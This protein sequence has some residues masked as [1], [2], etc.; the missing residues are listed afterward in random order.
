MKILPFQLPNSQLILLS[1]VSV[2]NR[3]AFTILLTQVKQWFNQSQNHLNLLVENEG[4]W[5]TIQNL[6]DLIPRKDEPD[7]YGFDLEDFRQ[8][9]EKLLTLVLVELDQLLE[10]SVEEKEQRENG[11]IEFT[12]PSSGDLEADLIADLC[13]S[14]GDVGL[15]I[16]E[17]YDLETVNNII[18]R[19]NYTNMS[20]EALQTLKDEHDEK[21]AR[22]RFKNY[23]KK[24]SRETWESHWESNKKETKL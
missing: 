13:Q 18:K 10:I 24:Y 4:V 16:L 9:P 22:I 15:M 6:V 2:S 8:C 21:Q 7:S 20:Q 17:L 19:L 5:L 12:L 1:P 23:G 14:L 11:H 3:S